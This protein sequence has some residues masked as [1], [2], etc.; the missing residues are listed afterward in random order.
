MLGWVKWEKPRDPKSNVLPLWVRKVRPREDNGV[1]KA[2]AP[3]GSHDFLNLRSGISAALSWKFGQRRQERIAITSTLS[4]FGNLWWLLSKRH[5]V[6][7]QHLATKLSSVSKTTLKFRHRIQAQ[8]HTV[9]ECHNHNLNLV[10]SDCK[11]D[12]THHLSNKSPQILLLW[13]S[14]I[15]RRNKY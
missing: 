14:A 15:S 6:L 12:H 2:A 7:S 10:L 8:W 11:P 5:N 1:C 3:G 9:H 4:Y 13:N